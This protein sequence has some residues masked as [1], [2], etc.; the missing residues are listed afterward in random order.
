MV[1]FQ[2]NFQMPS[3]DNFSPSVSKVAVIGARFL[4]TTPGFCQ[5]GRTVFPED[6]NAGTSAEMHKTAVKVFFM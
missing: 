6:G 4:S 3:R 2:L 1:S 5:S